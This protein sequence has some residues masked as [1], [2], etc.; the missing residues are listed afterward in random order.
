MS[1]KEIHR[2]LVPGGRLGLIW[3]LPDITVPWTAKIWEFVAL[4][5]R[6]KSLVLP[7]LQ[8]WKNVFDSTPQRLFG[9]LGENQSFRDSLP[10]SFDMG[11]NF[12]ASYSVITSGSESTKE[13]FRELYK[14]VMKEDF[15]DKGINLDHI[16][17]QIYINW[18]NKLV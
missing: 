16:P 11:Y 10:S 9:D 2:V 14:Q 6:E 4:L 5:N 8:E 12:F 17:F 1:L 15:E 13:C 7:Y 3:S 18:C